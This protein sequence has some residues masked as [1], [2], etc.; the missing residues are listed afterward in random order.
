[1]FSARQAASED[2]GRGKRKEKGGGGDCTEERQKCGARAGH[3]LNPVSWAGNWRINSL[4][5]TRGWLFS[6]L[7]TQQ[8]CSRDL[9]LFSSA[10]RDAPTPRE[11]KRKSCRVARR[12]TRRRQTCGGRGVQGG[13]LDFACPS[14]SFPLLFAPC[15]L[16]IAPFDCGRDGKLLRHLSRLLARPMPATKPSS[17]FLSTRSACSCFEEPEGAMVTELTIHILSGAILWS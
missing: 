13:H 15:S 6:I 1:M 5:S 9:N 11:Q 3:T 14:S 4:G 12:Q 8:R 10:A 17:Y 7:D 16:P 2:P